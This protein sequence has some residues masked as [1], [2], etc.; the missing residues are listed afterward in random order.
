MLTPVIWQVRLAHPEPTLW[1]APQ[2]F[3]R[4]QV[5]L[6]RPEPTLWR[7]PRSFL[8][9]QVR[10]AHPELNGEVRLLPRAAREGL[11]RMP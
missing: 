10:L 8:R 11:R 7:A 9:D 3:L 4:D 1:R 5:R 6:A 2:S